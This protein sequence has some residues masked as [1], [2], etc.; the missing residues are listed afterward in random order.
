MGLTDTF[1]LSGLNKTILKTGTARIDEVIRHY[2][3]I[4]FYYVIRPPEFFVSSL[5]ALPCPWRD[6]VLESSGLTL[7]GDQFFQ[8]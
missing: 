4:Y 1:L 2:F 8:S 3:S 6:I 7:F 5:L